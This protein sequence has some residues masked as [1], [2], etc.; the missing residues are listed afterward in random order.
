MVQR[1]VGGTRLSNLDPETVDDE[2]LHG[3][4]EQ[5]RT[6]HEAHLVHGAL[7]A[8]HIHVSDG[9]CLV[10]FAAGT[11]TAAPQRAANDVAQLLATTAGIV[12]DRRAVR[13]AAATLGDEAV[14]AALPFLQPAVLTG[15]T[16][17]LLGG[18]PRAV[19]QH[20]S[21][22]RVEAG[23][24]LGIEPPQLVQLQRAR[25]SSI[26]M[27]VGTLVAAAVLLSD[28]GEPSQVVA[29]FRHADWSWIFLAVGLSFLSN[30]GYAMGLQGTVPVRLPLWPTTELQVAVSF[31]N[32]AI[33][34]IGGTGMQIRYLQ[35]QGV[36]LS[37]AIAAG[38]L[39]ATVG[40]LVVALGLFVL[41][42]AVAPAHVNFD[43]LPTTGLVEFTLAAVAVVGIAIAVVVGIPRLR[44][45]V[46]P[47]MRRAATT[48][49]AVLRSPYQLALLLSG[50]VL[51]TLLS[52]W[53]LQACLL[54]FGGHVSFWPLLA[55][56]I[57]VVT[58]ASI[59]PIPGGGS[60]V[61]T[62]GLTAVLV[63]F[64][65]REDIAVATSLANQLIFYYLPAIPGWFA[66]RHL[67]RHDY[68]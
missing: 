54:A 29:T 8:E 63:T 25:T 9:P 35:K 38:G 55:A 49:V 23:D 21:R 1:P 6:L 61:G 15:A 24:V 57:G 62:V 60:A 45:M 58:I 40:N 13:A 42:L 10:D 36:D 65:V 33:P 27:A 20:L 68:L 19:R 26:A 3:I 34:G 64:G 4:W 30:V 5:V 28:V 2:L 66:T 12:G 39:L 67:A 31:T 32:L 17:H 50:N 59:V 47:P 22:L 56:N 14:T 51:A 7:D 52:A 43:L 44:R 41:A 46:M 11:S 37:S 16:R 48:L 18:R 53:C